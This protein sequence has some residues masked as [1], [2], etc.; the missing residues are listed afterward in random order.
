MSR[1]TYIYVVTNVWYDQT[2]LVAAFTV[3]HELVTW[4]NENDPKRK[5]TY[6]RVR[7]GGAA[8]EPVM[9]EV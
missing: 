5:Y 8:E 2:T 4:A 3:K 9:I 1:S 6:E 7:D